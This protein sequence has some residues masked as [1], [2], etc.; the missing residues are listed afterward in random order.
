MAGALDALGSSDGISS[1]STLGSVAGVWFT[2]AVDSGVSLEDY[3]KMKQADE[4][5][6]AS[7]KAKKD[8]EKEQKK[9]QK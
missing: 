4:S 1:A 8:A 2:L 6:A 7:M 3:N 9:T 5:A